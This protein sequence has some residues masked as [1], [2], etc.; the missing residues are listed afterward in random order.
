MTDGADKIKAVLRCA[1]ISQEGKCTL[2]GSEHFGVTWQY[3][4][5][6]HSDGY[7][8][9]RSLLQIHSK[10][11]EML[12]LGALRIRQCKRLGP[13]GTFT[14]YTSFESR[15]TYPVK[16]L[17]TSRLYKGPDEH[18]SRSISLMSSPASSSNWPSPVE[19]FLQPSATKKWKSLP[20]WEPYIKKIETVRRTEDGEVLVYFKLFVFHF[21]FLRCVV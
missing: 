16:S 18:I 21:V 10:C 4:Q 6:V 19:E 9:R 17:K 11:T 1:V 5:L 12:N 15:V 3:L 7:Y 2:R 14:Q 20:S 8:I 13:V